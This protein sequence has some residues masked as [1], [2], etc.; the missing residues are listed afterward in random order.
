[1]VVGHPGP[2][3][4]AYGHF[5]KTKSHID[6]CGPISGQ[7][8]SKK[9]IRKVAQSGYFIGNLQMYIQNLSLIQEKVYFVR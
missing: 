2:S 8:L 5:W 6:S 7:I 9:G 3:W 4:M 1:M